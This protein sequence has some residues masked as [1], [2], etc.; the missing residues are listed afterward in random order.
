MYGILLYIQQHPST[1]LPR[2]EACISHVVHRQYEAL[3]TKH[4]LSQFFSCFFTP[5]KKKKVQLLAVVSHSYFLLFKWNMPCNGCQ[6]KLRQAHLQ[7]IHMTKRYYMYRI[8]VR[9]IPVCM[10]EIRIGIH[11]I[12]TLTC[13]FTLL[14]SY[15]FPHLFSH[16]FF[17]SDSYIRTLTNSH[18]NPTLKIEF[19]L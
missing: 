9:E 4:K 18:L 14:L 19:T 8:P 6:Q 2:L 17:H 15:L 7:D 16:S 1:H 13:S 10:G 12:L 5:A 3:A 11:T